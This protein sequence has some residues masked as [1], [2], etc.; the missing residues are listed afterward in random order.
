MN[1]NRDHYMEHPSDK[2]E[3]EKQ[4][5]CLF[6]IVSFS[7]F[8]LCAQVASS[9]GAGVDAEGYDELARAALAKL[10]DATSIGASLNVKPALPQEQNLSNAATWLGES[11]IR[12]HP[13][14]YAA[15]RLD[16]QNSIWKQD[17]ARAW[18]QTDSE[19]DWKMRAW[20]TVG[21]LTGMHD[22]NHP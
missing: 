13:H 10:R 19:Y 6:K 22:S 12:S 15:K 18:K 20:Y 16:F 3:K 2:E 5:K 7:K 9:C 21:K 4:R 14:Y 1:A 11:L 17:W 8:K